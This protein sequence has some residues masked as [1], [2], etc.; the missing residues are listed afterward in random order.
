MGK[1]NTKIAAEVA[2]V[3]NLTYRDNEERRKEGQGQKFEKCLLLQKKHQKSHRM[4]EL[5]GQKGVPTV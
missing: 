4:G 3:D 2:G 1:K 5:R